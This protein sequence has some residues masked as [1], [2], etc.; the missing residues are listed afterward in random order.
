MQTS[1]NELANQLWNYI[2]IYAYAKEKGYELENPAFFEYG[3]YFTMKEENPIF[4]FFFF[5]PFTNYTKRKTAFR[6][7]VWRKLYFWYVRIS[8]YFSEKH[9]FSYKNSENKPYYLS[10]TEKSFGKLQEMETKNE[11]IYLDSWLFRNPVGIEKYRKEI[12]G[13]FK[14]RKDIEILVSSLVK[15]WRAQHK[16]LIGVHIRQGDYR[17]W[18]NGVYFIE[19]TRIREI[20]D[21]YLSVFKKNKDEILF[22]ITSDG[23]IDEKIFEGLNFAVSKQNAVTDLFLLA[24]TDTIIGSNSTFGAF[25]SYYGN[26]PLIVMQNT[27]IDWEYYRDK[28]KYFENEYCTMVH[29]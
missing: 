11:D 24:S 20:I 13:Y 9:F 22:V 28:T 27:P 16:T 15:E 19:Q 17:S 7:K 2:S 23:L 21:E 10:P 12:T 1:G 25:A 26:I 5:A 4:R 18:K 14:P 29:Y 8:F 3:N 6:R